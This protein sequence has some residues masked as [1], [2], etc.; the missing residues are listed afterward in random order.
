MATAEE[1]IDEHMKERL[2]DLEALW[3]LYQEGDQEHEELGYFHEYGL[4]FDYVPQEGKQPGFF[5]Y[6]LST[7]GPGDEFRFYGG[8]DD[9]EPVIEYVFLDWF[10][11]SSRALTGDDYALLLE[12]WEFFKEVGSVELE[13]I[14]RFKEM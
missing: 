5:R 14:N 8:P 3:R 13:Y 11:G 2:H 10:D 4:C 9:E 12:I 7:G 6:Q 1:R